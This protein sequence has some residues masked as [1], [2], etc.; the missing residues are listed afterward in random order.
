[1]K[2]DIFP[3]DRPH[4]GLPP[5]CNYEELDTGVGALSGDLSQLFPARAYIVCHREQRD[6]LYGYVLASEEITSPLDEVPIRLAV[7]FTQTREEAVIEVPSLSLA[8]ALG[9]FVEAFK[10]PEPILASIRAS[11]QNGEEVH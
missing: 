9:F 1:M 2:L 7:R 11:K 6:T 10:S 8:E 5:I 3:A 4:E